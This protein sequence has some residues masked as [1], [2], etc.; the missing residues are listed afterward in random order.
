VKRFKQVDDNKVAYAKYAVN[1][2]QCPQCVNDQKML[3]LIDGK[4]EGKMEPIN[5]KVNLFKIGPT[6]KVKILQVSNCGNCIEG[7]K[8]VNVTF[9]R[10]FL[11]QQKGGKPKWQKRK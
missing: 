11:E 3:G 4:E 8:K 7:N 1:I 9:W 10:A 2:S 5:E 6:S